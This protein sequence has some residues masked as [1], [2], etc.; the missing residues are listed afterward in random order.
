METIT[1]TFVLVAPDCPATSAVV[2]VAKGTSAPV[3]LIQY[4]LLTAKPYTLTLEDLIFET[5]VRRMGIS[6]AEAKGRA[7]EIRAELFSKPYACMRASA[8]PKKYGWGVHYDAAGRLALYAMESDTYRRF[9]EGG[10]S[11]VAVVAALRRKRA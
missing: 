7:A 9:A 11:G 8:L 5:H 10:M 3:H 2:P 6:K 1:N 4:Q